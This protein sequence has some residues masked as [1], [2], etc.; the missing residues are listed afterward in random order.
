MRNVLPMLVFTLL[1][2]EGRVIPDDAVSLS[3]TSWSYRMSVFLDPCGVTVEQ[4]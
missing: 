3:V 2:A 1:H 4:K